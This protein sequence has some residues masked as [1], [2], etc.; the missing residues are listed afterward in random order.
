MISILA[1]DFRSMKA[2]LKDEFAEYFQLK[3]PV[4]YRNKINKGSIMK[5]KY[6]YRNAIDSGLRSS[7]YRAV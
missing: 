1:F 2:L 7:Q 6:F 3:Y 5:P 4:F